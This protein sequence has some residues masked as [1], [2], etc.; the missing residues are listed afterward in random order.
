MVFLCLST[1]GKYTTGYNLLREP[2][3]R[4]HE[5]TISIIPL[6]LPSAYHWHHETALILSPLMDKQ[7]IN[8]YIPKTTLVKK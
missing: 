5:I 2:L 3:R 4:V 8:F 7:Y 1:S 6:H